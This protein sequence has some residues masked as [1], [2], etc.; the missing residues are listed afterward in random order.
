[1]QCHISIY[2][3][4][5]LLKLSTIK[6]YITKTEINETKKHIEKN[7]NI[8]ITNIKVLVD[9]NEYQF[10]FIIIFRLKWGLR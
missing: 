10:F 8:Q 9:S 4:E 3:D 6:K 5:K 7:Y 1:M 2:F